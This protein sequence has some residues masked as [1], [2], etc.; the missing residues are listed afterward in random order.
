MKTPFERLEAILNN[1]NF[2]NED[3][4]ISD[5][6][7]EINIIQKECEH[8]ELIETGNEISNSIDEDIEIVDRVQDQIEEAQMIVDILRKDGISPLA[9]KILLTRHVYIDA[10]KIGLPSIESLNISSNNQAIANNIADTL[11]IKINKA[12]M[13]LE[14]VWESIKEK[15][16]DFLNWLGDFFRNTE[17]K[18]NRMANKLSNIQVDNDKLKL[19]IL[20]YWDLDSVK[21]YTEKALDVVTTANKLVVNASTGQVT[22]ELGEKIK[23]FINKNE[24]NSFKKQKTQKPLTEVADD[25]L[26]GT[27]GEY[28]KAVIQLNSV[29][30]T[31]EICYDNFIKALKEAEDIKKDKKPSPSMDERADNMAKIGIMTGDNTILYASFTMKMIL[32]LFKFFTNIVRKKVV[33][34]M[35]DIVNNYITLANAVYDCKVKESN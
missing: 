33:K 8:E 19:K 2:E 32:S 6:D 3:S 4:N 31:Y 26:Q 9:L 29:R 18:V 12:H 1:K 28:Y 10:W 25:I 20:K 22:N 27:D 7:V 15:T 14:G 21:K 30:K 34:L 17:E 5:I 35:K 11:E 23:K 13:G 24:I 16:N